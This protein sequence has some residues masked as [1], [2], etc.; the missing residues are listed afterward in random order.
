[1]GALAHHLDAGGDDYFTNGHLG[2]GDTAPGINPGDSL[3]SLGHVKLEIK[4]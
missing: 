3:G 1:M 4:L 2:I